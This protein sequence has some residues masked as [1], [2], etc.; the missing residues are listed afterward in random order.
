MFTQAILLVLNAVFDLFILAAL[1][2]FWMQAFRA[3]V[4][5]PLGQFTIALT[6]WAVKPLRRIVP[7]VFKLDWASL[8]VAGAL[9][10]VLD[11]L[12]LLLTNASP[13]DNPA[14]LSVVL[15]LAFV[16]LIRYS[17]YVFMGALIIMVVLSW[18]AP[19]HPVMPFF[20][21]LTRPFMRPARRNIPPIGG[22]DVSPL[23]VFLFFQILLMIPVAWLEAQTLRMVQRALL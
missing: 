21:A 9:E 2:R 22:V 6:D 10:F 23:F 17:I 14:V 15:F 19:H 5:N 16:K 3:P 18:V 7:G 11:V 8:I 12:T 13:F 1:V 4:F 20:D